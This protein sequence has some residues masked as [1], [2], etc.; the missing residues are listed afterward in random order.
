MQTIKVT[1]TATTYG[2][3]YGVQDG[4]FLAAI[5]KDTCNPG[6]WGACF[7]PYGACN[8]CTFENACKFIEN[9][10]TEHFGHFGI[11]VEY[12]HQ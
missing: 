1:A 7:Q 11:N 3:A 2:V 12:I 4:N 5:G 10:I 8:N 9:T 6:K